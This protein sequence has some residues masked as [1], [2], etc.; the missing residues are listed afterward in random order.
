M[1]PFV[2]DHFE[3]A[4]P[5]V[6]EAPRLTLTTRKAGAKKASGGDGAEETVTG[7]NEEQPGR[8]VRIRSIR[9]P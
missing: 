7:G 2:I 3:V 9:K 5:P 6:L 8:I 1:V 4:G